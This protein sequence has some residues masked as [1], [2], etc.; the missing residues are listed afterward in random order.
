VTDHSSNLTDPIALSSAEAEHNET[1]LCGMVVTHLEMLLNDMEARSENEDTVSIILDS[2]SAIAMGNSFKDTKHTRHIL[3]RYHYVRD[4]IET[5]RFELICINTENQFANIG[6]RQT[7]GPRHEFL[8]NKILNNI[9]RSKR[10]DS[11]AM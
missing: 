8:M 1:C 7:P 5:K 3:R 2:K 4:G 6:T 9:V 11:V 10:D